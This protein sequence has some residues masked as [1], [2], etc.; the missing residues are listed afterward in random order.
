MPSWSN[1]IGGHSVEG[2]LARIE[3]G[4]VEDFPKDSAAPLHLNGRR[5]TRAELIA[6][7]RTEL[8]LHEDVRRKTRELRAAVKKRNDADRAHRALIESFR[9]L[10]WGSLGFDWPRMW[11][12]GFKRPKA[13]RKLTARERVAAIA[14]GK[15]TRKLRNT[16]GPKQKAKIKAEGPVVLTVVPA[17]R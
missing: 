17:K 12:Y 1:K 2:F 8:S 4:L 11:K 10:L 14:K 7:V 13:R 6:L 15:A 16:M 9:S 5:Y 3:R